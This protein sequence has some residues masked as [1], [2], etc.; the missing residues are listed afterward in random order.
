M[1]SFGNLTR[2]KS[3]TLTLSSPSRLT[4]SNDHLNLTKVG[5]RDRRSFY[6]ASNVRAASK[7]VVPHDPKAVPHS[8]DLRLPHVPKDPKSSHSLWKRAKD[9][10]KNQLETPDERRRVKHPSLFYR[11]DHEDKSHLFRSTNLAGH[12]SYA[13]TKPKPNPT[14]ISL[15]FVVLITYFMTREENDIDDKIMKQGWYRLLW[16]RKP[17][18]SSKDPSSNKGDATTLG[19]P[20]IN[21]NTLLNNS[22]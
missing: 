19:V 21:E 11:R 9:R 1:I 7:D 22:E 5:S 10:A 4:R 14:I 3:K 16:L 6:R 15:S 2:L 12:D 13:G 8:K 17:Y 18:D 20:I